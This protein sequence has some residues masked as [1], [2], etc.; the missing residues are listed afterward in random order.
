[1]RLPFGQLAF[2][3]GRQDLHQRNH[4]RLSKCRVCLDQTGAPRQVRA[5]RSTAQDVVA[6]T[7]QNLLLKASR[8]CWAALSSSRSDS[9]TIFKLAAT[10][11]M[12]FKRENLSVSR[13]P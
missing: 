6:E 11:S 13:R 4:F 10:S 2:G 5:D 8:I 12:D 1:M 9:A 7:S 3:L